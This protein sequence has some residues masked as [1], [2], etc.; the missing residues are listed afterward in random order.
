[1]SSSEHAALFTTGAPGDEKTVG[2]AVW[3][4]A[5]GID[6]SYEIGTPI[7]EFA[8]SRLLLQHI[9][10][11]ANADET[12]RRG[13]RDLRDAK[14]KY[15]EELEVRTVKACRKY[16]CDL[17]W[18]T[19]YG[20][21]KTRQSII[22]FHNLTEDLDWQIDE[23]VT[24]LGCKRIRFT[25]PSLASDF[26]CESLVVQQHTAGENNWYFSA[27]T[28]VLDTAFNGGEDAA[29]AIAVPE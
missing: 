14:R 28:A 16:G 26:R 2:S 19:P 4:I 3:C 11:Q 27:G 21:P 15:K 1:M 23:Y 13:V 8:R 22:C 10:D 7:W 18:H 17:H 20:G 12:R 5:K 25:R 9:Q 29:S 6:A 24:P